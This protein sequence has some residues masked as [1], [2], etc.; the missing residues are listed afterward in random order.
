MSRPDTFITPAGFKYGTSVKYDQVEQQWMIAN[1]KEKEKGG[2][3][4]PW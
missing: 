2:G 3:L 4:V 1:L